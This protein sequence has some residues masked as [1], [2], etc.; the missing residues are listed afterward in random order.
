MGQLPIWLGVVPTEL[1]QS[2]PQGSYNNLHAPAIK[3]SAN[4]FI[5]ELIL[6]SFERPAP[7]SLI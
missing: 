5:S 7:K 4:A 2:V 3:P 6:L 1:I